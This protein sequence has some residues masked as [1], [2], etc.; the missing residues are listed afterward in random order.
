M[1]STIYK[2]NDQDEFLSG[3]ASGMKHA[4]PINW[5][6]S[7][8]EKIEQNLKTSLHLNRIVGSQHQAKDF[9]ANI[10]IR[11]SKEN[12]STQHRS[13]KKKW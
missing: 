5:K 11:N 1:L 3:A 13:V 8:L 7:F 9:D 10:Y 12:V 2:Q 6:S 4:L